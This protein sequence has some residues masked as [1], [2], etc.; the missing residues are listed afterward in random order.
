MPSRA[1]EGL[2]PA[3]DIRPD[4][5]VGRAYQAA[6]VSSVGI[7]MAVATVIGWG[8]GYYFDK[9][10][11]TDPWLMLVGLLIG[12]AAGFRGLLRTAKEI[13]NEADHDSM[14]SKE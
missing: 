2:T 6:K 3:H 8:I 10:L 12:V 7:E 4:G 11:G 5:R 1:S 14:E 9:E 13:S